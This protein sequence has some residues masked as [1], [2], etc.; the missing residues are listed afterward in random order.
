MDAKIHELDPIY[1]GRC[2][3]GRRIY[4]DKEKIA[5]IHDVPPCQ[6]FLDLDPDKFLTY[7]RRSR[8]IPDG[9]AR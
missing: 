2:V 7:V 8:G 9:A 4:A 6:A 1:L 5:V 3:C